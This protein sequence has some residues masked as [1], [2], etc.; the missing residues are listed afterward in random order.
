MTVLKALAILEAAVLECKQR[1]VDTPGV[2][3]ALE[4]LEP[5]IFPTWLVPQL[6]RHAKYH[7]DE[8]WA[9]EGQQRVLR[10]T[11][12]GIRDSVKVLL[13]VRM[14]ALA[15]KFH[16]THDMKVKEEIERLARELTS[17]KEPWRF[18]DK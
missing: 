11:F 18:V 9:R 8:G 13:E 16:E 4:F 1:N 15:R 6:R 3:E 7:E 12:D 2:T 14:D 10:P 17:L 5:Y